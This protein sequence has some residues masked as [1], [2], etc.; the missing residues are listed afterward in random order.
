[1]LVDEINDVRIIGVI[2]AFVM[3]AIALAGLSWESKVI[4]VCVCSNPSSAL[5][6]HTSKQIHNFIY[7]VKHCWLQFLCHTTG[8]ISYF[9]YI[10]HSRWHQTNIWIISL[11]KKKSKS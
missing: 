8:T 10:E 2:T 5:M 9:W 3:M 11:M 4:F 1:L 6:L 7:I